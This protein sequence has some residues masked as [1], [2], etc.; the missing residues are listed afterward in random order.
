MGCATMKQRELDL[1]ASLLDDVEPRA[2]TRRWL[3]TQEGRRELMAYRHILRLL[4]RAYAGPSTA[5]LFPVVYYS[6]LRTP[7]GR[8][9]VAA[10]DVG[11][12]RVAFR[13]TETAFA[14]ELR[15]RLRAE[16]TTSARK[17]APAVRQLDAYFR[18]RRRTF[19]LPLDLRDL[20]PF[21]RRV[22]QATRD[23]PLGKVVSYG[24]IAR[25]VDCPRGSRAVGQALGRN[26]IPIVIPCHRIVAGG[27]GLG[28]YTG[29]LPIK[30]TLLQLE[31]ALAG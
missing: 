28:G 11:L 10:T 23:V 24:E 31:G 5:R 18:G 14:A 27:G 29:G 8:V 30:R 2:A 1:I 22:L 13:E 7:I 19:D 21:Q 16:V 12:V 6:A 17:L 20:T 4:G 25:R 9:F 15:R 26:P 3:A